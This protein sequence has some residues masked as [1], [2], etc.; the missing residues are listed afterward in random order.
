MK[1]TDIRHQVKQKSRYS[2]F[3]DKKYS[4]SLSDS[5]IRSSGLKLKQELSEAEVAKWKR[6]STDGKMFDM[7]LRWLAIRPRSRGELNDYFRKKQIEE[8]TAYKITEKLEGFG[9]LD[10]R[11]FAESWV[12]NRRLLKKVSIRRLRQELS[13]KRVEQDIVQEVLADDEKDDLS[14]LRELIEKKSHTSKFKDEQKFMAFLARQGFSYTDIKQALEEYKDIN[15][16]G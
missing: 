10:D 12:R 3:V 5:Q 6:E 8:D 1:I 7:T 15:S 2:I 14:T 11:A 4:F 9:Y 16:P 13:Q